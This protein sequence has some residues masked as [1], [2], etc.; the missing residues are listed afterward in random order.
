MIPRI[1]IVIAACVGFFLGGYVKGRIDNEA[2]HTAAALIEAQADAEATAKLAAVEEANRALARALEDQ[3]YADPPTAD[4]G[5]PRAR[6]L[7]LKDR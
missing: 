3:A 6:V 7:R 2:R 5:L 1:P 4:C